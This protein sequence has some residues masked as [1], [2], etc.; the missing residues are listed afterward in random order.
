MSETLQD[1]WS[2]AALSIEVGGEPVTGIARANWA[3]LEVRML[4]PFAGVT[5]SHD[6]RGWSFALISNHHPEQ[7][8]A[9]QGHLTERGEA[10]AKQLLADI[11]RDGHAIAAHCDTVVAHYCDQL[12]EEAAI[13]SE[14]DAVRAN[15]LHRCRQL[16]QAFQEGSIGQGEYQT[17]LAE[18][19]D[20]L[21]EIDTSAASTADER[22]V[23]WCQAQLGRS[24]HLADVRA[25]LVVLDSSKTSL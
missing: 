15:L 4:T 6:S 23:T 19:R 18:I 1:N 13:Q 2:E 16:R 12:Q 22:M 7:R 24:I 11:H 20:R 14:A 9:R 5:R 8:F 21:H 3:E 25:L 17:D 10:L